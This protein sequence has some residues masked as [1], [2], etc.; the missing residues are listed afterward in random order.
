VLYAKCMPYQGLHHR[1]Q[2][3]P[4]SSQNPCRASLPLNLCRFLEHYRAFEFIFELGRALV[5]ISFALKSSRVLSRAVSPS[6]TLSL[7][8]AHSLSLSLSSSLAS[9]LSLSRALSL[10]LSLSRTLYLSLSLSRSL[11]I[12]NV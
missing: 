10:S 4:C 5:E 8:R 3:P 6:L 11:W 7:S 9:S 12:F 1:S 2:K